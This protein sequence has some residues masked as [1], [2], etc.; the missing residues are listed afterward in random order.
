MAKVAKQL[1]NAEIKNAKAKEKEYK[2]YEFKLP[3]Q[4]IHFPIYQ[5]NSIWKMDNCKFT[6]EFL[7]KNKLVA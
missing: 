3:L 1:T 5:E 4:L 6:N 2:L 7:E